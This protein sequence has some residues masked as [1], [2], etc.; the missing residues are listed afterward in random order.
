M[1]QQKPEE[2]TRQ[3]AAFIIEERIRIDREGILEG[4]GPASDFD[5]FVAEQD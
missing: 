3:R 2:M 1:I 5:K 4:G